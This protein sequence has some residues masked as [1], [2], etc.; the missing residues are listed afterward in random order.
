MVRRG[1]PLALAVAGLLIVAV[2]AV[3]LWPR[4]HRDAPER[5]TGSGLPACALASLPPQAADTVR[6]VHS[7]GP[8]PYPRNDGEVFGNRE[9]QLPQ[10][11]RGYYHEYTVITPGASNRGM[12]R[13]ITGGVP[14]TDPAQ[15]FY[16]G[17]HYDSFC[18]VSGTGEGH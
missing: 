5:T 17:D 11:H 4:V 2:I 12:R 13:I 16:T 18:E 6:L 8:F 15:Y 3:A 14:L 7:G 10:Q 9:G 1:R